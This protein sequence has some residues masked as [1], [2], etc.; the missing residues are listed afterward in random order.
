MTKNPVN[1]E[2]PRA[3]EILVSV[4]GNLKT[5]QVYLVVETSKTPDVG[6]R[7]D[8]PT[9]FSKPTPVRISEVLECPLVS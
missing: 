9:S 1:R 8:N 3:W 4:R 6:G 7:E 2:T 5:T